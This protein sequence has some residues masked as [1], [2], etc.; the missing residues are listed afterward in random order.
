MWSQPKDSGYC[1]S[2]TKGKKWESAY[3]YLIFVHKISTLIVDLFKL[4]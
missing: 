3:A 4:D 1:I 2:P